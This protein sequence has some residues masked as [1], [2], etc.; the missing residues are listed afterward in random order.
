MKAKLSSLLKI[1]VGLAILFMLIYGV[2]ITKLVNEIRNMDY[3]L[4]IPASIIYFAGLYFGA[5]KIYA[6]VSPIHKK[7]NMKKIFHIFINTWALGMIT[8]GKVGELSIIYFLH[9]EDVNLGDGAAIA[10]LD[11]LVRFFSIGFFA[12]FGFF[13]FFDE[14]AAWRSVLILSGIALAGIFFIFSDPGRAFIKKYLLR[15]YHQKF[16]GFSS[17]LFWFLRK[18]KRFVLLN[19]ILNLI[20]WATAAFA[21]YILF[22]AFGQKVPFVFVF[23]ITCLTTIIALIPVS[24][25]GLGLRESASV[26]LYGLIG[27]ESGAVLGTYLV[28]LALNYAISFLTVMASSVKIRNI[29]AE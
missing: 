9:N 14:S 17:R 15:K 26:F 10:V 23:V 5:L 27:V 11:K 12:V 4:L 22:F 21:I 24:L 13:I 25:S 8:P 29:P 3:W 1:A 2:G 18:G 16:K 28:A 6:L 19:L 7:I 20:K